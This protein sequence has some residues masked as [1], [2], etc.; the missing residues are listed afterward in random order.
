MLPIALAIWVA[1]ALTGAAFA[2]RSGLRLA[3][4]RPRI[5]ELA[6]AADA[7]V[8]QA[9]AIEASV[10]RTRAATDLVWNLGQGR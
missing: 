5:A 3:R 8:L 7:L 10:V 2:I 6:T 4:L 1:G 9:A